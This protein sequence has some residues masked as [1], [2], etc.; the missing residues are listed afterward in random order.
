MSPTATAPTSS[1]TS[2]GHTGDNN[3]TSPTSSPLL[4]F[5]ALGF[6]VVFT[7]LW[8]IVGV[9]YCFRYNQRNRQMRGEEAGEP[10]DLITMPRTHRRRREKKLMS[11]DEVNE[12]FPLVKYKAW[13]SSRANEGLSTAGGIAVSV[14]SDHNLLNSHARSTVSL[15]IPLVAT[16]PSKDNRQLESSNAQAEERLQHN[17]HSAT[18][19]GEK[20]LDNSVLAQLQTHVKENDDDDDVDNQIRTA[21]PAELLANPG[22]TCAICLDSIEDDDD[23]RG[24]TCGH[25]FH[26]SC[27][28]PW[29]TSRRACCPLCKADYYVPKPRVEVRD[30]TIDLERTSRRLLRPTQPQAVFLGGGQTS[31]PEYPLALPGAQRAS[32]AY[33]NVLSRF[34]NWRRSDSGNSQSLNYP[35]EVAPQTNRANN[36]HGLFPLRFFHPR[37][38]RQSRTGN[39]LTQHAVVAARLENNRT[40]SQ[41]EAGPVV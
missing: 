11:M 13:C 14:T 9:K 26:A 31:G 33:R 25:A 10:I 4:F 20:C 19:L 35:I 22:D 18:R 24:L 29:L 5:V 41:L 36:R 6:G 16:S 7:N 3:N 28:D 38:S 32:P 17:G 37:T 40:L 1:A 23:I 2:T 27:V 15:D 21:V 30:H 34:G 12:R 39:G 8:I